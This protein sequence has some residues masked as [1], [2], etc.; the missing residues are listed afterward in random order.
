MLKNC[1]LRKG[2]AVGIILLF[3]G[4]AAV[5][6]INVIVVKASHENQ[7][8]D[9]ITQRELVFQTIVDF[10]NNEEIQRVVQDAQIRRGMLPSTD[11]Q[12][13]VTTSQLKQLYVIGLLLSKRISA[14]R[15]QSIVRTYHFSTLVAQKDL[16]AVIEK[17]P[18]LKAELSQLQDSEC[19]CGNTKRFL[20]PFP[21]LC[22][23]L[24]LCIIGL[25][26]LLSIVYNLTGVYC[27]DIYNKLVGIVGVFAT[28]LLCRWI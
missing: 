24:F 17:T 26:V 27:V 7:L 16:S 13:S 2:L 21:V 8:G 3:V 22:S 6:G 1:L 9:A 25:N 18:A 15:M 12:L 28:L 20:W 23:I 14:L 10:V 5:P 4:V 19:D 11:G